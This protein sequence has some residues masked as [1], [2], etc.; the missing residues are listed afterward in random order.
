MANDS[1]KETV[2]LSDKFT[3]LFIIAGILSV[4]ILGLI[5]LGNVVV[6]RRTAALLASVS[7]EKA[8]DDDGG[9]AA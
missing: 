9:E 8:P 4:V 3:W 7:N 2:D 1:R 6:N 5:K